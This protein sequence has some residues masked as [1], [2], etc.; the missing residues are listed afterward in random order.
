MCVLGEVN[1]TKFSHPPSTSVTYVWHMFLANALIRNSWNAH[2]KRVFCME[3]CQSSGPHFKSWHRLMC[4]KVGIYTAS[5]Q[6]GRHSKNEKCAA[7]TSHIK[8]SRQAGFHSSHPDAPLTNLLWRHC[9]HSLQIKKTAKSYFYPFLLNNRTGMDMNKSCR[10]L[11]AYNMLCLGLLFSRKH[12]WCCITEI[13]LV[14]NDLV[15]LALSLSHNESQKRPCVCVCV[16][17]THDAHWASE[18]SACVSDRTLASGIP[19]FMDWVARAVESTPQLPGVLPTEGQK[20]EAWDELRFRMKKASFIGYLHSPTVGSV[21]PVSEHLGLHKK[22][23][24]PS[25]T[26][27]YSKT[28]CQDSWR[29][30]RPQPTPVHM[31]VK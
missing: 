27:S 20:S 10:G 6:E 11:Q 5:L 19:I 16:W 13:T 24:A 28:K 9:Q 17:V 8:S 22:N 30:A 3:A 23:K 29:E 26:Q 7:H 21:A 15:N 12:N 31:G 1:V 2:P 25:Q 14:P 18:G 4:N